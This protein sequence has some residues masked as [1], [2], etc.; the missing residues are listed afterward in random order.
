MNYD[1]PTEKQKR[2]SRQGRC[3]RKPK[4]KTNNEQA[5]SFFLCEKMLDLMME[6]LPPI[7]VNTGR[8]S[9]DNKAFL[10]AAFHALAKGSCWRA[11]PIEHGKWRSVYAKF[12]RWAKRGVRAELFEQLKQRAHCIDLEC[13]MVDSTAAGNHKSAMGAK[14]G[15]QCI[16]RTAGC[17][18]TKLRVIVDA[19]GK[20]ARLHRPSVQGPRFKGEPQ[21]DLNCRRE[22]SVLSQQV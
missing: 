5:A 4:R 20:T 19:R 14:G 8:P 9:K 7:L 3:A 16:G 17:P 22:I 18:T 21:P 1:Q 6:I 10:V 2:L 13:I 12:N 11:L 15:D